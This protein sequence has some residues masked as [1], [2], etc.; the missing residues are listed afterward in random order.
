MKEE[1]KILI[2]ARK[3]QLETKEE[4]KVDGLREHYNLSLKEALKIKKLLAKDK[5]K[6]W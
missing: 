3:L 5:E 2:D 4:F 1:Y 6:K